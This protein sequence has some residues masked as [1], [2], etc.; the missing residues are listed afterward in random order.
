[1]YE[2]FE[3]NR[4]EVAKEMRRLAD[5]SDWKPCGNNKHQHPQYLDVLNRILSIENNEARYVFK[6]YKQSD[7]TFKNTPHINI[8][9]ELALD[10]KT[11]SKI[12][13]LI[14]LGVKEN[15]KVLDFNEIN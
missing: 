15:R 14:K 4:I 3:P 6:D 7:F 2:S 11:L 12:H 13:K 1:M 9:G 5:T 8:D 10:T